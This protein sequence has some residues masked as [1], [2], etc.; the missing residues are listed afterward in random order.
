[1]YHTIPLIPFLLRSF[2]FFFG[3]SGSR[4]SWL[5]H[6]QASWGWRG[7]WPFF[8]SP[9]RTR[10]NLVLRF[11][12]RFSMRLRVCKLM[13]PTCFLVSYHR[14]ACF[15]LWSV[16]IVVFYESQRW[17]WNS[18][19][20]GSTLVV[21]HRSCH[22]LQD[23]VQYEWNS[24]AMAFSKYCQLQSYTHTHTHTHTHAHMLTPTSAITHMKGGSSYFKVV[25]TRT[26]GDV[27]CGA[28]RTSCRVRAGSSMLRAVPS[29]S[30]GTALCGTLKWIF[31]L[32]MEFPFRWSLFLIMRISQFLL[33]LCTSLARDSLTVR[34]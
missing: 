2:I 1:M 26:C 6:F 15:H 8:F 14:T 12:L 28:C 3:H 33:N 5:R 10:L 29:V 20:D 7:L 34:S 21:N 17:W 18:M 31:C 9:H 23:T 24:S 22:V 11:F 27:R 4:F 32:E 25:S 13:I 19:A 30:C 16:L